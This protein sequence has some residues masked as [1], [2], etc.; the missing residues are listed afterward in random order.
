MLTLDPN[1]SV[2]DSLEINKHK[3]IGKP[4]QELYHRHHALRKG[5]VLFLENADGSDRRRLGEDPNL[6]MLILKNVKYAGY[7]IAKIFWYYEQI[8]VVINPPEEENNEK[9][10][11]D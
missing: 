4:L 8:C 11:S 2:H 7:P 9:E 10:K 5:F 1:R 3:F 6:S